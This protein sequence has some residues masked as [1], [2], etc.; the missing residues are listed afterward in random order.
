MNPR[1]KRE[2][3][4]VFCDSLGEEVNYEAHFQEYRVPGYLFSQFKRKDASAR[5]FFATLAKKLINRWQYFGK[6]KKKIQGE[7]NVS[8]GFVKAI[9][10]D[11]KCARGIARGA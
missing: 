4:F 10:R 11:R 8:C 1:L 3:L 9:T 5:R 6:K 7:R 2:T